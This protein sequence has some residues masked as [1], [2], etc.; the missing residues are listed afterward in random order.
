MTIKKATYFVFPVGT[1]PLS[2]NAYYHALSEAQS[3]FY[4]I[5]KHRI[6]HGGIHID[7]NVISALK[8]ESTDSMPQIKCIASG[9]IIAYRINDT[10]PSLEQDD[11]VSFY[12]SGF[13]LVRHLLQMDYIDPPPSLDNEFEVISGNDNMTKGINVRVFPGDNKIGFLSNGAQVTVILEKECNIAGYYWYPLESITNNYSSVPRLTVTEIKMHP[14]SAGQTMQCLGWI[15]L[16]KS[17]LTSATQTIT[18]QTDDPIN[19]AAVKRGLAIRTSHNTNSDAISLLPIGS[20]IKLSEFNPSYTWAK[21]ESLSTESYSSTPMIKGWVEIRHLQQLPVIQLKDKESHKLFFYSLY[22][23]TADML[24]YET[25]PKAIVPPYFPTDTYKVTSNNLDKVEG[26]NVRSAPMSGKENASNVLAVLQRGTKLKLHLDFQEKDKNGW[27]AIASLCDGYHSI[28]KLSAQNYTLSDGIT[29]QT[30]LGWIYIS[31]KPDKSGEYTVGSYEKDTSTKSLGLRVRKG[32]S[33]GTIASMLPEGCIINTKTKIDLTNATYVKINA[34][35]IEKDKATLPLAEGDYFIWSKSLAAT[36]NKQ[37]M[38]KIVVLDKP[39]PVKAGEVIGHVGHYHF[40]N[41]FVKK[42]PTIPN[43]YLP[44][45]TIKPYKIEPLLHV[46]LFTCENLPAFIK[47]TQDEAKKIAEEDKPFLLVDKGARLYKVSNEAEKLSIP[48]NVDI[49][50]IDAA[51]LKWVKVKESYSLT[52]NASNY[53]YILNSLD[54]KKMLHVD[55][56]NHS[57]LIQAMNTLTDETLTSDDIPETINFTGNYINPITKKSTTNKKIAI[58]TKNGFTDI[59]VTVVREN[60]TIWVDCAELNKNGGRNN[61][62]SVLSGWKNHPLTTP[63]TNDNLIVGYPQT[64]NLIDSSQ[65]K[66]E[67]KAIDDSKNEWQHITAGSDKDIEISGWVKTK[68]DNVKRVSQWEWSGFKQIEASQ[69]TLPELR[70]SNIKAE[71]RAKSKSTTN[72][73]S[74]SS[75]GLSTKTTQLNNSSSTNSANDSSDLLAHLML[76]LKNINH[77][78]SDEPLTHENLKSALRKPWLSEQFGHILVKY[79]SEWYAEI[80]NEEKMTKWEALNDQITGMM[81]TF[82]DFL[83]QECDKG[84]ALDKLKTRA[85]EQSLTTEEREKN[86]NN[87]EAYLDSLSSLIRLAENNPEKKSKLEETKTYLSNNIELWEKEKQRIKTLLWWNYVAKKLEE[88]QSQTNKTPEETNTDEHSNPVKRENEVEQKVLPSLSAN[89][90]AW[91]FHPVGMQYLIANSAINY[92][93]NDDG[94]I[95]GADIIFDKIPHIERPLP[96]KFN[97]IILHRTANENHKS[98][99]SGFRE[100]LNL[101]GTHFVISRKGDI[102]QCASLFKHTNHIGPIRMRAIYE[103]R[104]T[105]KEWLLYKGKTAIA[106]SATE[107]KKEYPDRFPI[108]Q[109]AIG[110]EVAANYNE[111]KKEWQVATEEQL[112]AVAKLVPMLQNIFQLTDDDLYQHQHISAKKSKEGWGLYPKSDNNNNA[113]PIID[114]SG[115][116][117][118]IENAEYKRRYETEKGYKV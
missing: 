73:E 78:D 40:A 118:A 14:K 6:W 108:N 49:K 104:A 4:P 56:K 83:N 86:I 8:A 61:L 71:N 93:V 57:Q 15:S 111:N 5:G 69:S 32:S 75:I 85:I 67:E 10:F 91:H 48:K 92:Y 60:K 2:Q 107:M 79:E 70:L 20:K 7:E 65:F 58:N 81:Q 29:N 113:Y 106:N 41:Q 37:F 98:V 54:T 105:Q 72:T 36:Q 38:N 50:I 34:N 23:H 45:S 16:G 30:I 55:S 74:A 95:E 101:L 42:T 82:L 44:V 13:V 66:E 12:S 97:A 18:D 39:L 112:K 80:D 90:K 11:K 52:I 17:K 64:I 47:K 96:G 22:M 27:Y 84:T 9:E 28:P 62:S 25:F 43:I 115:D 110:I 63:Q 87:S 1:K 59:S 3:G 116:Y 100:P 31:A 88:K 99:I 53:G 109:D 19:N 77:D 68:Q 102:Y 117:V 103:M 46:E 26:L 89:G 33:K 24:H 51:G 94:Y 114:E 21:V 76:I 35:D